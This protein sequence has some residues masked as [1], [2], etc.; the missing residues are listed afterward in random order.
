MICLD[1]CNKIPQAGALH[2]QQKFSSHSSGGRMSEIRVPAWSG[3]ALF[4]VSDFSLYS[5]CPHDL[6]TSQRPIT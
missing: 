4:W 1:C 2:K 5:F 6:I 3:R